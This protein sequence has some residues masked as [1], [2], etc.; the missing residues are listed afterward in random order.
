MDVDPEVELL[1][2]RVRPFD[3]T[4]YRLPI[5]VL[6]PD[7]IRHF[8]SYARGAPQELLLREL[9]SHLSYDAAEVHSF[10]VSFSMI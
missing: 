1:S 10:S 9:E 5:H 6:L 7:G 2:L 3:P 8:R 4:T